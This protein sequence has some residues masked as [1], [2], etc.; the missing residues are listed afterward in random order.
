[1]CVGEW[2]GSGAVGLVVGEGVGEEVGGGVGV[3]VGA[4]V[5]E[6]VGEPVGADVVGSAVG[7]GVGFSVGL[8]SLGFPVGL[9]PE[10][11]HDIQYAFSLP[12][13]E[14]SVEP[15]FFLHSLHL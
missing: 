4:F 13:S 1:M 10:S 9:T 2:V 14:Q 6:S 3:P 7:E 5:G 8:A 12:A 11:S 15:P